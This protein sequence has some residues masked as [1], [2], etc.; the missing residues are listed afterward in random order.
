MNV[1]QDEQPFRL[2]EVI[3]LEETKK[4]EDIG[5]ST[6][7][8]CLYITD[9]GK[10]CLW[11]KSGD[12]LIA[13]LSNV[14]WPFT[15]SVLRDG[16]VLLP[17]K[18]QPCHV[19]LYSRR[20]VL[21]QRI[22]LPSDILDPFHA[23]QTRRGVLVVSHWWRDSVTEGVFAVDRD[24]LMVRRF[25]SFGPDQRLTYPRYLALDAADR[26]FVTDFDYNQIIQ[27]DPD[28]GWIRI[29]LG[30]GDRAIEYPERLCYDAGRQQLLVG[31]SGGV[32]VFALRSQ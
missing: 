22:Q 19:E 5:S 14:D 11:R 27:L 23:I 10:K 29:L 25:L 15:V 1:F 18:G 6:K 32:D 12:D 7:D 20:G 31:H 3:T 26:V 9:S 30:K 24:G 2:I 28:L 17:R 4:P 21:L 16:R 13:W 8:A